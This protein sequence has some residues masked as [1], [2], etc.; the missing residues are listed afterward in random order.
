MLFCCS[1]VSVLMFQVQ[2]ELGNK[3]HSNNNYSI[4]SLSSSYY[5]T[6]SQEQLLYLAWLRK[7]LIVSSHGVDICRAVRGTSPSHSHPT[8]DGT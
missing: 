7:D 4:L 2:R 3:L 1:L 5:L 6:H 8:S